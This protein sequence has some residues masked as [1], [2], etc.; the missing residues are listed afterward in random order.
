[1]NLAVRAAAL[2]LLVS[3]SAGHH[4]SALPQDAVAARIRAAGEAPVLVALVPPP[5]FGDA[6]TDAELVRA[7][8]AQAQAEVIATLDTVDFRERQR[9]TSIP[10]FAGTVRT[11]RGLRVLLS[12]PAVRRVDL[13]LAGGGTH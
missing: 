3:C 13:D 7:A 11:E 12:H 10:A 5:G 2:L 1:M 4:D 9:F 6:A 8:I